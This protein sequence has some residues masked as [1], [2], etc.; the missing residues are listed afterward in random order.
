[1]KTQWMRGVMTGL[2]VAALGLLA[3]GC[4]DA[5]TGSAL[6]VSPSDSEIAGVGATVF[7]TAARPEDEDPTNRN[8]EVIYP[9]TWSVSNPS[10]GGILSSS[11]NSAV[12]ESNGT[13]G[14]NVVFARDQFGRE[15]LAV[16]NQQ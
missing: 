3:S 1:M 4:E 11:G 8:E 15:G 9:L 7:L 10:L 13:R 16:I 14:Q 12:Y 5:E 2:L 6:T